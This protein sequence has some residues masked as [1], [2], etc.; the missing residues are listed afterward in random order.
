M[1]ASIAVPDS[2]KVMENGTAAVSVA[3]K[4]S[5]GA[6]RQSSSLG[7]PGTSPRVLYN[8]FLDPMYSVGRGTDGACPPFT[9]LVLNYLLPPLTLELW[10]K[11]SYRVCADGG[12]NRLAELVEMAVDDPEEREVYLPDLI[13][14]DLDSLR[15]A[16]REMYEKA[17]IQV[18]EVAD[19][20]T[21]DLQK[22]LNHIQERLVEQGHLSDPASGGGSMDDVASSGSGGGQPARPVV[23]VLG[24]LGGRLDHTIANL[25]ILGRYPDLHVVL[26]GDGNSAQLVPPG[27][28]IIRPVQGVEGP[29]CGLVPLFTGARVTSTGLKWNLTDDVMHMSGLVSTSNIVVEKQVAVCTDQPLIWTVELPH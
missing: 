25:A 15:P 20:D 19:Q 17:G 3:G 22:S 29:T 12:A 4:A 6:A 28:T 10:H 23:A 24:G 13:T 5:S 11:A 9:L 1:D 14:G 7:T 2:G 8:A 26:L 21:T 27:Q 18:I 16:V